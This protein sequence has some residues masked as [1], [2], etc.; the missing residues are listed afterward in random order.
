[1]KRH[2]KETITNVRKLRAGGKEYK[3]IAADL[4]IPLA[5]VWSM[6]NRRKARNQSRRARSKKFKVTK[7][8][9]KTTSLPNQLLDVL[10]SNLSASTKATLAKILID[11]VA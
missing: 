3:Q 11:H 10:T 5:T 9:A 1:M 6:C 8:V 7:P 4:H 2:S